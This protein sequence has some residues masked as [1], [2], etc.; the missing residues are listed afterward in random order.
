MLNARLPSAVFFPARCH[1]RPFYGVTSPGRD[2]K[3]FRC[4]LAV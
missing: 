2:G 1:Y 3:I 4:L